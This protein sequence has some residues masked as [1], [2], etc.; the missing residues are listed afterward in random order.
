MG[1][2]LRNGLSI[3]AGVLLIFTAIRSLPF[4]VRTRFWFPKYVHL[5][6]AIGAAV[7]LWCLAGTP[8]DA[9]ISKDGPL[10]KLLF[11]L[12]L[13][14]VIYFI[15]LLY[16]GQRS[17][18][19]SRFEKPVSCPH[20]KSPLSTAHRINNAPD[21]GLSDLKKACPSCGQSLPSQQ[22]PSDL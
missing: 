22:I 16:G 10:G 14:A 9:P 13:P 12:A 21:R 6:A 1:E 11:V 4:W 17:A 20:C 19:L 15:F 5:M 7:M 3:L 8:D 2:T 18:Y